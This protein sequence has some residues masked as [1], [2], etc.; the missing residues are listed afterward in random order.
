[1]INTSIKIKL[2]STQQKYM[3][4]IDGDDN[5]KGERKADKWYHL[6]FKF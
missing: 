6:S 5:G 3:N 4:N 2:S 1:M